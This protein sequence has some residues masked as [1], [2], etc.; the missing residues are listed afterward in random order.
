METR[1]KNAF[2]GKIVNVL[3]VNYSTVR[4]VDGPFIIYVPSTS[5][6]LTSKTG[7]YLQLHLACG[8]SVVF[9]VVVARQNI[10]NRRKRLVNCFLVLRSPQPQTIMTPRFALSVFF[11]FMC[12]CLYPSTSLCLGCSYILFFSTRNRKSP[13]VLPKSWHLQLPK[14]KKQAVGLKDRKTSMEQS[15][16]SS[17]IAWKKFFH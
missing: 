15:E 1:R 17:W 14:Q 10:V 2:S 6:T 9:L 4:F 16:I 3:E 13:K 7:Q 8:L 12:I 5:T 11:V